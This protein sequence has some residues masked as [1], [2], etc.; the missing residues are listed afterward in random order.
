MGMDI[1][2]IR[3][4]PWNQGPKTLRNMTQWLRDCSVMRMKLGRDWMPKS[5]WFEEEAVEEKTAEERLPEW[6][7][8]TPGHHYVILYFFINR[9][10]TLLAF[11]SVCVC[12]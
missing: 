11:F 8:K 9:I 6:G 12:V 4:K 7:Y 5:A 10:I 1:N 2:C 3:R